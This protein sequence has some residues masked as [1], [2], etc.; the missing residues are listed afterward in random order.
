MR[1]MNHTASKSFLQSTAFPMSA[2][3]TYVTVRFDRILL[4]ES[5]RASKSL[6]M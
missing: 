4:L 6:F 5:D 1:P 2:F 3:G